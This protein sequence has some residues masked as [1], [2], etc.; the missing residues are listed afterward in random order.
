M[1]FTIP[2]TAFPMVSDISDESIECAECGDLGD[3][4]IVASAPHEDELRCLVC[5]GSTHL[6]MRVD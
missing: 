1:T 5:G 2:D 6:E 4:I 3:K